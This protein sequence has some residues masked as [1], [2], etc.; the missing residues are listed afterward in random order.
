VLTHPDA[1][2]VSG[3]LPLFERYRVASV[4]DGAAPGA[5][6]ADEWGAA[7]SAA[8]VV[9]RAARRGMRVAAG[10]VVLTVLH[11]ADGNVPAD[12]GNDGSV[13]LRLEY[14]QNSVL[15][16][17]D[18][19]GDAEQAMLAGSAPLRADVLKV[20]HHGS[21]ASTAPAFLAAVRPQVAIISVGADNRFGHPAPEL[22]ERLDGI[23]VLRTDKQGRVELVGD[24][25][26]W[27]VRA[28]R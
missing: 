2:H 4:I 3:L 10:P 26:S 27:V 13:V 21:A 17:G 14:G 22:L 7:V 28:E 16:T 25:K 9:H 23:E 18:A 20:A 15:L 1:D 5:K 19:E 24:G 6:G 12:D 8:A 11:P